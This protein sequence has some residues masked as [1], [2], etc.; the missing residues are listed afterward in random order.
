M[1]KSIKFSFMLCLIITTFMISACSVDV[2][3]TATKNE[4]ASEVK[5]IA[6]AT[7]YYRITGKELISFLGNPESKEPWDFAS[8]NGKKYKA[9][10]YTYDGGNQEFLSIDGK[11]VRFT[12]YGNGM[13][14]KNDNDLYK[15][16]GFV[17]K[18]D[19]KIVIKSDNALKVHSVTEK[20]PEFWAVILDNEIDT[21]KITYD[22][23]YF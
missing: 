17:P 3:T 21:V 20:I 5:L 10:T 22:L 13:K 6:D 23:R 15:S 18:E 19:M 1:R 16:F 8:P 2:N 7:K 9:I 11:I 12:Y 14:Y 4:K